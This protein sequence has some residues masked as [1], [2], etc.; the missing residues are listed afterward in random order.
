MGEEENQWYRKTALPDFTEDVLAKTFA[1]FTVPTKDEGFDE[2]AFEW[3]SEA[4]SK[5]IVREYVL[6]Q[7][8]TQKVHDLPL[9]DW[10]KEEWGAWQKEL[11]A[12]KAKQREWKD[13]ARRKK[14]LE[15]QQKKQ[16]EKEKKE[17]EKEESAEKE[18]GEKEE[19]A[20]K[21][22]EP[23]EINADDIEPFK[24]EDVMDIGNG[25]PLFANFSF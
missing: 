20:E 4:K 13:P 11:N 21:E 8:K 7:K 2:V 24:V 14:K 12:W 23:M 9:T 1:K 19:G 10:F 16:K 18:E 22:D 25:E 6:E 3:Q 5:Q 15:E 17:K